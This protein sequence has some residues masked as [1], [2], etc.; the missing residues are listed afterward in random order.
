MTYGHANYR[1]EI[2]ERTQN[3]GNKV[4]FTVLRPRLT[5]TQL[6]LKP[7][8]AHPTS[9][10]DAAFHACLFPTGSCWGSPG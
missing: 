4:L 5:P 3:P 6:M 1:A 10:R 2:L 9:L 7:P 8:L